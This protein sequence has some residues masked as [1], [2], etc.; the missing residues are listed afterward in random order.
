[1]KYDA[2]NHEPKILIARCKAMPDKAVYLITEGRI[3]GIILHISFQ[4]SSFQ[5]RIVLSGDF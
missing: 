3:F 1:M 2:R 4:F 5:E